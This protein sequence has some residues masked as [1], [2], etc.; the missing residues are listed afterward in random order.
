V[1]VRGFMLAV[2][3]IGALLAVPGG[4]AGQGRRGGFRGLAL[5]KDLGSTIEDK[6]YGVSFFITKYNPDLAGVAFS[7]FTTLRIGGEGGTMSWTSH[8]RP[9]VNAVWVKWV[10]TYAPSTTDVGKP[11]RFIAVFNLRAKHSI[12]I[13]GPVVASSDC[14]ACRP[15]GGSS[16]R[17]LKDD[18]PSPPRRT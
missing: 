3:A 1:V 11:F 12:G 18:Q 6:T 17:G 13:D 15:G 14:A 7:D 10:G 5:T 8:P 4:M 2:A 16:G 9:V